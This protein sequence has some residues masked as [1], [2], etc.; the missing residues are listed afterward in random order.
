VISEANQTE[1]QAG[2]LS[3][4]LGTRIPTPARLTARRPRSVWAGDSTGM[5]PKPKE[6]G[7]VPA[8]IHD[9]IGR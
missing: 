8:A 9:A 3:F 4:F 1:M 2:G 5:L 7:G 6:I